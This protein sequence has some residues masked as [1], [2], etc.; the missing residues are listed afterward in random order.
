MNS[1]AARPAVPR[2]GACQASLV[3]V[4]QPKC[5]H[6]LPLSHLAN[7]LLAQELARFP[8]KRLI[9]AASIALTLRHDR[10][11]W[12]KVLIC[13][14]PAQT[15][16]YSTT[17]THTHQLGGDQRGQRDALLGRRA[18]LCRPD[19]N[20]RIASGHLLDG[21]TKPT[22]RHL[23]DPLHKNRRFCVVQLLSLW[24]CVTLLLVR[25]VIV[26][27]QLLLMWFT[28]CPVPKEWSIGF[29]HDHHDSR[30]PRWGGGG[31]AAGQHAA[32]RLQPP[33]AYALHYDHPLLPARSSAPL[34]PYPRKTHAASPV[35]RGL[36]EHAHCSRLTGNPC[37]GARVHACG[38]QRS[39]AWCTRPAGSA[40]GAGPAWCTA[41]RVSM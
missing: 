1:P 36:S 34:P 9:L 23:S 38:L 12:Q 41:C 26:L 14:S 15:Q 33:T 16:S 31:C 6:F 13:E 11:R 24:G 4:T 22:R 29:T 10:R 19:D 40:C 8:G 25:L 20:Q 17:P 37:K 7:A 35:L 30:P 21:S 2:I 18:L 39:A 28:L 3:A 27:V 5:Q 32:A